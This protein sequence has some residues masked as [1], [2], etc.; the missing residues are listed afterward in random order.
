[1]STR[2]A[3]SSVAVSAIA[4]LVAVGS[5]AVSPVRASAA[6]SGMT[7]LSVT[8]TSDP[9]YAAGR[10]HSGIGASATVSRATLSGGIV[11]TGN[12]SKPGANDA[13]TFE[14]T[15]ATNTKLRL[16]RHVIPY[17]PQG[18]SDYDVRLAV[19]ST[20]IDLVGDVDVLDL[21][22]DAQGNLTRFDVV[23]RDR[24]DTPSRALFGQIRMGQASD[25]GAV[26]GTTSIQY[27]TTPIGSVPIWTQ[28]K[29]TNTSTSSIKI[30]SASVTNGATS[31]FRI[32]KNGCVG[33]TL[34]PG[35]ACTFDVGFVPT[36]AGPRTGVVSVQTGTKIKNF[37]VTGS[38][39]LGTT[40]FKYSGDDYVSGGIAHS[41]PDGVNSIV[42]VGSQ[43]TGWTFDPTRPYGLDDGME[44]ST[45]KLVRYDSGRIEPGT[46]ETGDTI[47]PDE[48]SSQK[49]GLLVTGNGRGCAASIGKVKIASFDVDTAGTLQS[50]RLSWTL[51][52]KFQPGMMTGS[53][54]WRDRA[55]KTAPAPVTNL[56]ISS[57][58]G[59]RT[60]MWQGSSSRDSTNAVARVAPGS[61][62]DSIPTSGLAV[63]RTSATSAV[64]PELKAGQTYAINVWSLDSSGNAGARTSVTIVG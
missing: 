36:K 6:S 33:K 12:P 4:A 9:D 2:L 40:A 46:Y 34:S 35:A 29:V 43:D 45:V 47:S 64:L 25:T 1:M 59:V 49:Y 28:Q 18:T 24:T 57:A 50:A 55:D 8:S 54:Q 53:L 11:M 32:A 21:A 5:L 15:P 26:F 38:A 23:F 30:G 20:G 58:N 56:R 19:G 52:C 44:S 10:Q 62:T 31:D 37:A 27:P 60:V 22:A 42:V 3:R 61:G 48:G 51:Q 14:M 17:D 16:G 39:P 41:F 13:F 63:T 7:V